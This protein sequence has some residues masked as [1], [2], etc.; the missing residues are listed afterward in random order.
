LLKM[1]R[2][3]ARA[4]SGNARVVDMDEL[5]KA[6]ERRASS[7]R[8]PSE[9]AREY[10]RDS[11]D[12]K[13]DRLSFREQESDDPPFWDR[14]EQEIRQKDRR[15]TRQPDRLADRQ[16]GRWQPTQEEK[17]Q[18]RQDARR[19]PRQE[20]RYQGRQQDKQ[21]TRSDNTRTSHTGLYM[22]LVLL[23]LLA[24]GVLIGLN[25]FEI[26]AV[27]V[28]G[29]DTMTADSVIALSGISKGEN[30]FKVNLGQARKNLESDPLLEVI[31]ISRA[32][33]D[34]IKIEVR[35][36]KPHGAI[37]YL[38]TYVI[39]D[40][41]G[42]VLDE[43]ADLPAGQYPLV[44]GIDI[45]PS[46][47][48]KKLVGVDD[49]KLKTMYGLLSALYDNKAMPYISEANIAKAEDIK[50]LTGEGMEIDL[51]K[52]T[53]LAKK[54]Q[55]IA[56]TIPELRSKG[57]TSGV[58]YV[59]GANS[60]V[61]SGTAKDQ[62]SQSNVGSGEKTGEQTDNKADDQTG[63]QTA[64]DNGDAGEGDSNGQTGTAENVT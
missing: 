58:L 31:G 19:S 1:E 36:R 15:Q 63:D 12:L 16:N 33:P 25:I 42:F 35:Q 57:H 41:K 59:T 39:I 23:G 24:V 6:R 45:Q 13:Q 51:G 55:W 18:P 56:C 47:K 11:Q 22:L 8:H 32:F 28:K 40:E 2:N 52:P 54:A 7:V 9:A 37:A 46:V 26:K 48:G 34:K 44:T 64:G 53:E 3:A 60:P 14:E 10:R 62:E 50:L 38:G 29:N 30:I 5:K 49:S 61:Y 4:A 20:D 27:E 17:N 43:R 21:P